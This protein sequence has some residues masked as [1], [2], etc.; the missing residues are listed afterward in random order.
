MTQEFAA[1]I[2]T[3]F[4]AGWKGTL[5][6]GAVEGSVSVFHMLYDGYQ[7]SVQPDP[8]DPTSSLTENVDG[9]KVTGIEA[10][11]AVNSGGLRADV[12]F[13]Y[14]DTSFGE[15]LTT[16]PAGAFGN[17]TALP[18]QFDGLNIPFAPEFSIN[19]GISYEIPVGNGY[20]TPSVRA[21]YVA[22]QYSAF[23]R[24]PYHKIDSRTLVDARLTYAPN[25]DF[26]ITAYVTNL[27]DELYVSNASDTTNGVGQFLLGAPQEIGLTVGFDF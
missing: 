15:Q 10:Q 27:F 6:N 7:A 2:V 11:L 8:T 4:E 13:S 22:E 23:F 14:L 12:G 19:G 3:N 5:A 17:P 20:L 9:T 21:S 26:R 24:L 1:E 16:L 25:D 18:F